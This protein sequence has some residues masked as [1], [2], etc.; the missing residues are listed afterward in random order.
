[1]EYLAL[2][3]ISVLWNIIA[4]VLALVIGTVAYFCRLIVCRGRHGQKMLLFYDKAE[5]QFKMPDSGSA[6]MYRS[7]FDCWDSLERFFPGVVSRYHNYQYRLVYDRNSVADRCAACSDLFD[8]KQYVETLEAIRDSIPEARRN[9]QT[10]TEEPRGDDD[11]STDTSAGVEESKGDVEGDGEKDGSS[12]KLADD[13]SAMAKVSDIIRYVNESNNDNMT[14]ANPREKFAGKLETQKRIVIHGGVDAVVEPK[15]VSMLV[16]GFN[17]GGIGIQKDRFTETRCKSDIAILMTLRPEILGD[18]TKCWIDTSNIDSW[19]GARLKTCRENVVE[20]LSSFV[21]FCEKSSDDPAANINGPTKIAYLVTATGTLYTL[22][23]LFGLTSHLE[24]LVF[25]VSILPVSN[26]MMQELEELQKEVLELDM[27]LNEVVIDDMVSRYRDNKSH[28][29]NDE[30]T[31][32]KSSDMVRVLCTKERAATQAPR[33]G[34]S[35]HVN[36][37]A[38]S[39]IGQVEQDQSGASH[40]TDLGPAFATSDG[41]MARASLMNPT[42]AYVDAD[43]YSMV[44]AKQCYTE[45]CLMNSMKMLI[46]CK[47]VFC[48]NFDPS[49]SSSAVVLQLTPN[50]FVR[51]VVS[52]LVL[53]KR[54]LYTNHFEVDY[55]S[56]EYLVACSLMNISYVVPRSAAYAAVSN[57]DGVSFTSAVLGSNGVRNPDEECMPKCTAVLCAKFNSFIMHKGNLYVPS[58]TDLSALTGGMLLVGKSVY[59]VESNNLLSVVKLLNVHYIFDWA[60]STA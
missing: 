59:R 25:A 32:L 43:K 31:E 11:A 17:F 60:M 37:F 33:F 35:N 24:L 10:L 36:M 9:R 40:Q 47:R 38:P 30:D 44:D 22:L 56:I 54:N 57:T 28:N 55:I 21:K 39:K 46:V 3:T 18:G 58:G 29:S 42:L 52:D 12:P 41:S 2:V 50:G 16:V 13:R 49:S 34:N 19:S 48:C 15:W 27:V 14:K 1:M 20:M 8:D 5:S 26:R 51:L 53:F 45:L 4:A 6:Y 23:R 7:W